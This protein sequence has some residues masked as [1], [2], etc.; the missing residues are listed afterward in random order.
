MNIVEIKTF[1]FDELSPEAQHVAINQYRESD[2]AYDGWYGHIKEDFHAILEMIG[3][4]NIESQFCGF[5]SQGDGAS[6]TGNYQYKKGCLK[7]IKCHAPKDSELHNIV[8]GIISHQKD[9]GYLL[10]CEI[11]HSGNYSHSNTMRFDWEKGGDSYFEWKNCHVENELQQLFKDLADWY[12]SRLENEYEYQ[13][14]DEC[15]QENI[16]SNEYDFLENGKQ[17]Y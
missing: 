15:I 7:A 6:F 1:K 8:K 17:Y 16:I 14:S 11:Y 2:H 9:N 3:V 4:Y 5:W 12:Y 13:N 10:S